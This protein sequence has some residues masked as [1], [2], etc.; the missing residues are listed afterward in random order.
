[1]Q[2]SALQRAKKLVPCDRVTL[3]VVDPRTSCVLTGV[4]DDGD[5]M[6]CSYRECGDVGVSFA[7]YLSIYLSIYLCVGVYES[8][9]V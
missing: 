2:A 3:W 4:R 9:H 7:I 8:K 5:R 6:G 1:M